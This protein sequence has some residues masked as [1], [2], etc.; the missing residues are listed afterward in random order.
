[1]N[2]RKKVIIIVSGILVIAL[3]YVFFMKMNTKNVLSNNKLES[4]KTQNRA[5]YSDMV[6]YV[7]E[8]EKEFWLEN[9]DFDP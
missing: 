5:G 7:E 2:N 3:I 9:P 1:M 4:I 6:E 8:S